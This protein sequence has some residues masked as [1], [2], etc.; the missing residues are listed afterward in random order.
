MSAIGSLVFCTD[1]GNLLDGSAGKQNVILTCAA[2]GAQCKDTSSKTVVTVSKPT[3]FPSSLRA[4]RS[5]VQTI[6]EEDVQTSSV[7]NHPC[8]KCGREEVRY[9]TQQ[10]R[11]ADEGSTVFYECDCGHK[12]VRSYMFRAELMLIAIL[13]MEYQQLKRKFYLW[14]P[15]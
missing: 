4:K 8:E 7:I 11:S 6:S 14:F 13:Q 9:Y 5:E 1:C 15:F 3:A 10:L 2:C 12:Y